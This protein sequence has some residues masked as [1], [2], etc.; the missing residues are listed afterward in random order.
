MGLFTDVLAFAL[1]SK[2]ENNGSNE[3]LKEAILAS[4]KEFQEGEAGMYADVA[5]YIEFFDINSY[6]RYMTVAENLAFGA[7]MDESF[8]QEHLHERPQFIQFLEDHGLSA[9][10][11]VLGETLARM[12][13]AE[14]G[15]EPEHDDFASSPITEAEYSEYLKVGNRL[16]SGEPL[17]EEE[18]NLILKL[19]LA[20][21]PGIHGQVDLDKG[22]VNRVVRS[23]QDFMD[24]GE[25]RPP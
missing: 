9:H 20:Y 21:I 17:S 7:P 1:R 24:Q 22:F 6:S 12:I 4:R 2:L 10:L 16:D 15:S 5:E 19:A 8:D 14:L 18:R 11:T 3:S 25:T 23:R 13:T